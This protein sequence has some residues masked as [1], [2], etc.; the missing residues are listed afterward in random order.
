MSLPYYILHVNPVDLYF[1][2]FIKLHK[3]KE[4]EEDTVKDMNVER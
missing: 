1:L 2:F 3:S 4:K